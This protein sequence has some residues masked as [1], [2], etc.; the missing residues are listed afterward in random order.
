M[1]PVSLGRLV[2]SLEFGG[3]CFLDKDMGGGGDNDDLGFQH[4]NEGSMNCPS[5]GMN[6]N[7]MPHKVSGMA[8]SSVSMY[9]KSSSGGDHH[10]F[11]SGWDP[12]VSLSQNEN[13][14]VSSMVTHGEFATAPYPVVMENQG[15]SG[16]SHLSQY[17]PSDSS[18][19]ELVP[20]ISCFGSGNFT[21]MVS[22]Y[23]LH[24]SVQTANSRRPPNYAP[25]K[26]GGI[27]R[28]STNVAHSYED[29]QLP[30]E[31]E[32]GASP[33]GKRRKQAPESNLPLNPNKNA[34][35]EL[36]KDPSG[37]SSS[38]KK[39]K[40]EH[41]NI[42][43]LRGKQ[44]SKQAKDNSHSEEAPKE[45][46]HVRAKRGQA[47][48]SHSLAERVRREKISERMRLLQE[49]VPGCN[50]ITGKA[51]MLDEIINY[52]QSL[53]QQVEFLSMKLA[54]VNPELN[55]DLE[56]IL[57]KDILHSR[58]GGLPILGFS[59]GMNSSQPY[60]HG[61]FPGTMPSI[62]STNPQFPPL[63]QNVLDHELQSLFQMGFDSSSAVDSLGPNGRLK[64][65]L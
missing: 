48:N 43:N 18:F 57:S 58:S 25:N 21:D 26:E 44:A 37:E 60:P 51:V 64:P 20:K 56:R 55:I 59:P 41:N 17:H 4:R 29:R 50:K 33:N 63:S 24:E 45:Y 5:S 23:G 47:T 22:S 8:M 9:N 27:E 13:F 6:T 7:P 52:V 49:L 62:P 53:Q 34:Q 19:V 46:I 3:V 65:E 10:F 38:E 11:G 15:I 39:S 16:T 1:S 32:I 28:T 35:E 42:A 12:I 40:S 2:T 31:T 61:L 14:G 54:T 36:Q 30:E